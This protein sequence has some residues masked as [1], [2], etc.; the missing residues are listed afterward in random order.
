MG[1]LNYLLK[2]TIDKRVN[3]QVSH[4]TQNLFQQN[5]N[6]LIN[7]VQVTINPNGYNYSEKAFEQV[8]AVYECVDLIVKKFVAC[9]W[10]VYRVKSQKDYKKYLQACEG[11]D[12]AKMLI[13]KVNALEEVSMPA[14]EKLLENPNP[15]TDG[16]SLWELASA[17]LLLRGNTYLYGNAGNDADRKAGKWSELW[18]IP[19]EMTIK[20]GQNFMD[21]VVEYQMTNYLQNRP[22]PANQIKHIK[23]LNP[24]YDPAG[25]QGYGL[26][27]LKA[28]LYSIDILKNVDREVDKQVK[29]GG[30]IGL[31]NPENKEDNW[32]EPQM[33]QT[34]ESLKTAYASNDRLDRIVPVAIPLKWTAIGLPIA[35]LKALEASDAKADD[36]YRGFHVPLQF[37]SQDT[38]TYN[39]LPVANRQLAYNAIAPY[40]RK[41]SKAMTAFICTPYNTSHATY[42]V[43]KD[44]MGLPE[45][46]DDVKGTVDYLVKADFLSLNEKREVI[47]YGRSTEPG[48]DLIWVPITKTP[49]QS[50]MDGTVQQG[51]AHVTAAVAGENQTEKPKSYFEHL[52]EL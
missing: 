24:R 43:E 51:A 2:G 37:R 32:G 12:I 13:A 25:S 8:G 42:I 7:N 4:I 27:V 47:G 41:F 45:L 14:I 33:E 23:T 46:Q 17:L 35:D 22:F 52:K 1:I 3:Q 31:L 36:I 15:E 21:P 19:S 38:A 16:D 6:Q 26:P 44:F 49:M 29:N 30:S 50:I 39:N 28:Y 20:A 40:C 34:G 5:L 9:P 18:C 48:A 11:G 10:I